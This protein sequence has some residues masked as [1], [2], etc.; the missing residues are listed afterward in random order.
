MHNETVV[1]AVALIGDGRAASRVRL[2]AQSVAWYAA[3]RDDMHCFVRTVFAVASAELPFDAGGLEHR[4][5]MTSRIR[6][7]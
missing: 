3:I 1:R 5:Q 4:L 2:A 6:Y 7:R